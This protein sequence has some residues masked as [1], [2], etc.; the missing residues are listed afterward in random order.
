M[1]FVYW[2]RDETNIVC[3]SSGQFI[4]G[5]VYDLDKLY[6]RKLVSITWQFGS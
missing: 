5:G 6:E 3:V 4:E 1:N 2:I